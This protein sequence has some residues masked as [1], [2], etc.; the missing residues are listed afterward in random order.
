[1]PDR[2]RNDSPFDEPF[3]SLPFSSWVI[4]LRLAKRFGLDSARR[5]ILHRIK[6]DFPRQDPIDLLEAAKIGSATH[7]DWL[8]GIYLNLA[9][10][11]VALSPGDIRRV[12]AEAAADVWKMML[13][14]K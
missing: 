11:K 12:G 13:K 4:G 7:S 14:T 5:Y 3:L 6:T 2:R 10:R 8:Q 1:M 9:Q